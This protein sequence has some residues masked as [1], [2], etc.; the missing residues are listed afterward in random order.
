MTRLIPLWLLLFACAGGEDP[1]VD[2]DA[3][4]PV[5]DALMVDDA[6]CMNDENYAECVEA[7]Q[8]CGGENVMI[9]ES[10]PLQFAC[11]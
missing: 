4:T 9:M 5:C 6:G 7:E 2:T 8:T 10:C 1:I 11:Q 3:A